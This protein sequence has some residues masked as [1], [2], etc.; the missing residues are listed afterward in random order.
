MMLIIEGARGVSRD[1]LELV[2]VK[3]VEL[4]HVLLIVRVEKPVIKLQV[5]DEVRVCLGQRALDILREIIEI[6][7]KKFNPPSSVPFEFPS[8]VHCPCRREV[9][10]LEISICC[11]SL[12][13]L[14]ERKGPEIPLARRETDLI[15]G[16]R[17]LVRGRFVDPLT[18][19]D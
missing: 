7:S 10:D 5:A 15:N 1:L 19:I 17:A 4:Y 9:F 8:L 3:E 11:E 14:L 16:L 13:H 6:L 18:V 12:I 2:S